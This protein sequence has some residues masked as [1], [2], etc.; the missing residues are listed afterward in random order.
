M[1]ESKS[2]HYT[3]ICKNGKCKKTMIKVDCKDGVCK[4]QEVVSQ[5][6]YKNSKSKTKNSKPKNK[7]SKPKSKN[8]KPKNKNSK[9][10]NKN[11]KSKNKNSKAKNKKVQPKR[12]CTRQSYKKYL[13]RNSPPYPANECCG[14]VIVGN[15]GS[16]YKSKKCGE[17]CRWVKVKEM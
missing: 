7:K 11:S 15:D 2:S 13:S 8:S 1:M 16:L 9:S 12:G 10:K 14:R 6:N 17:H 4:R 5:S 3:V